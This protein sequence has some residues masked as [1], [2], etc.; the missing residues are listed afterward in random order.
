MA[1]TLQILRRSRSGKFVALDWK[2][3]AGCQWGGLAGKGG[4]RSLHSL[5]CDS[6]S[7]A[8][9]LLSRQITT[10]LL[11]RNRERV[12]SQQGKSSKDRRKEE[13]RPNSEFAWH[14]VV[15][16]RKGGNGLVSGLG[17]GQRTLLRIITAY[18]TYNDTSLYSIAH[19]GSL[20]WPSIKGDET[21]GKITAQ[22]SN[23]AAIEMKLLDLQ[24]RSDDDCFQHDIVLR[25]T[26]LTLHSHV[27]LNRKKREKLKG[28]IVNNIVL[29]SDPLHSHGNSLWMAFASI[30]IP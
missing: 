13:K 8:S 5:V 28:T 4:Y 18:H 14:S 20:L 11:P 2:L 10:C 22:L 9:A 1:A 26:Y 3:E 25:T 23:P 29:E 19:Y 27:Y 17:E 12:P 6:F 16:Q 21:C 30:N 15:P 24:F 7:V